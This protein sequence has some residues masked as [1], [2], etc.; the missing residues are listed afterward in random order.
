MLRG[1]VFGTTLLAVSACLG[2]RMEPF[3]DDLPYLRGKWRGDVTDRATGLGLQELKAEAQRIVEAEKD[4]E[5]WCI[6]KAHIFATICDR[7]SVGFSPHD[8]FPAFS[9]WSRRDRVL[10]KIINER[11]AE[12]DRRYCP[13]AKSRAAQVKGSAIRHDYDHAVPDWDRV[14]HLGFPGIK[15]AA[16]ATPAT[17]DFA[18]AMAIAADAM[19]RNVKRIAAAARKS[20]CADSP[21]VRAEVAALDA[22]AEG[23]PRTAYEAMMFQLLFFVYGEHVDHL[24]VR[25]LGNWDR[26]M[27]PYYEADIAAGRT[28][29]EAFKEQV[30]H[31]WWQWGSIDNWWGQPVYIG[32]TKADGSTEYGE[33]SRVVLE[34]TDELALPTPK[35]Q[36]KIAANTPDD[37]FR[38]ALDMARRHRSVVFCGEEPMA[39]AMAA[40][41]FTAEEAR[42]LDIWGCYEFQPRAAANTTLPCVMNLPH[43]V[44]DLLD[45]ARKGEF[46]AATFEE[47]EAAFHRMMR[48]RVAVALD[49]VRD[50]ESHM[51]DYI[52][53]LVHS[54]SIEGCV[55]SGRNA[56][57]NGMKYN[58][59][60]ILQT[61]AGT[62]V[63]ALAA[64]KEIVYE[65]REM[66]L[67]ELGAV[68]ADDWKGHEELRLRMCASRRKWG[69]NDPLTNRLTHDLYRQF[70]AAVNGKPNSRDGKFFT[71]GHSIDYFVVLGRRTGATPDGRRKGDEFSKNISPSPGA[72]REGP[73]ALVAGISHI[74]CADIPGDII[75][76]TM[77]HPSLVHG[78]KG[79]EA[80]KTL[81]NR[82][83]AAGGCAIHFNVFS[84][85][86]LRDAQEHPERYENLQ[87]RICGWNVRWND[88]TPTQQNAYIRRAENVMKGW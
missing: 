79:L 73:T 42:T 77:I 15:A 81:V 22:L 60:L 3:E 17:N 23:P 26:L 12:I 13:D 7:M 49:V 40:M 70:G 58:L 41:G 71:A 78:E 68:M 39:K 46:E 10:T 19:L 67:G 47:F 82:Y 56:I 88:L 38:K 85:E 29:R 2:A 43:M 75:L 54:L 65:K 45:A 44:A 86:E 6:V 80:M 5:P 20:Q 48:E 66:T 35:L 52:P 76:D 61:G 59:T 69:N 27:R 18:R 30:K 87:V 55:R 34:V 51:D 9:C 32:G 50:Y 25:S 37:I 63:D 72:D 62:A 21:R 57:G 64:V 36:L 8:F 4:R 84:S 16:D 11:M 14:L 24:Q 33:V 31:F 28:T 1:T 74:D 53:A 83:F